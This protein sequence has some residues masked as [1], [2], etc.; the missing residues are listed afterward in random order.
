MCPSMSG[1]YGRFKTS[2]NLSI[3]STDISLVTLTQLSA[4]LTY[5]CRWLTDHI[6]LFSDSEVLAEQSTHSRMPKFQRSLPGVIWYRL[7]AVNGINHKWD[8]PNI[9]GGVVK[10]MRYL[11]IAQTIS[12]AIA[13]NYQTHIILLLSKTSPSK[14][15]KHWKMTDENSP[16]CHKPQL[17][18]WHKSKAQERGS[19]AAPPPTP[20]QGKKAVCCHTATKTLPGNLPSFKPGKPLSVQPSGRVANSRHNP[21]FAISMAQEWRRKIS[22][23][24]LFCMKAL[25]ASSSQGSSRRGS[26]HVSVFLP[27]SLSLPHPSCHPWLALCLSFQHT[28]RRFAAQGAS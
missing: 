3:L 10:E 4:A 8:I 28:R 13:E 9:F 15:V 5:C 23:P 12:R 20:G 2:L 17:S 24:L 7:W 27:Q 1:P 25:P 22:C 18:D 21:W 19:A 11:N 14:G 16:L 26:L 6:C